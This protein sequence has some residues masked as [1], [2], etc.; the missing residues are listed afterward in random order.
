MTVENKKKPTLEEALSQRAMKVEPTQEE[1]VT[2]ALGDLSAQ[3]RLGQIP[4]QVE[5]IPLTRKKLESILESDEFKNHETPTILMQPETMTMSESAESNSPETIPVSSTDPQPATK[6]FTPEYL[7]Q[8]PQGDK[9]SEDELKKIAADVKTAAV[10]KDQP[11]Q[12]EEP[13]EETL[14]A[15]ADP[16][17]SVYSVEELMSELNDGGINLRRLI[18]Y[19]HSSEFSTDWVRM[20]HC[21]ISR[22]PSVIPRLTTWD[23]PNNVDVYKIIYE[24][25]LMPGYIETC[26]PSLK[27]V[28]NT[29]IDNVEWTA[30]VLTTIAL[31]DVIRMLTN[32]E[33]LS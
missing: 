22:V 30:G 18:E 27:L 23:L 28:M 15:I 17:K 24:T 19:V 31:F 33:E 21:W 9:L 11:P 3:T 13:N 14:D 4:P 26:W 6:G 8:P 20:H 29:S 32:P 2:Q 25:I 12:G 16:G 1:I 5:E 10:Q 7:E